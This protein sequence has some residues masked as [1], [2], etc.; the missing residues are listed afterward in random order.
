MKIWAIRAPRSWST[1]GAGCI[2]IAALDAAMLIAVTVATPV[3]IWPVI[4]AMVASAARIIFT[5]RTLRLVLD[6]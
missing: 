3:V 1:T 2:G 5:T 4:V 6:G